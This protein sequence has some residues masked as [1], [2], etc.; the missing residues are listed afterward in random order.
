MPTKL[1]M[2]NPRITWLTTKPAM[3][4]KL[5]AHTGMNQSFFSPTIKATF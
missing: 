3:E 4:M 5:L 2:M 1:P